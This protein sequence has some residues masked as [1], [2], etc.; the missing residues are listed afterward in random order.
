MIGPRACGE[1]IKFF[2]ASRYIALGMA[3]QLSLSKSNNVRRWARV[4]GA[5]GLLACTIAAG[6]S[7]GGYQDG[8]DTDKKKDG[9]VYD[10]AGFDLRHGDS[11]DGGNSDGGT[12]L[13]MN[14]RDLATAP[15]L[16]VSTDPFEPTSCSAPA[17]SSTQALAIL[18]TST[19]M[20]L[21][22]ATLYRRQRTCTGTTP[23][24]CGAWSAAVPHEQLL[25]TYSGGVTTD[26]K[27]FSFPTHLILFQQGGQPKLSIRHTS[28]YLHDAS[29]DT[30]GV[31]FAFGADPMLNTYPVI[32]VWDFA[33]KPSRYEDLAGRLGDKAMLHAAEHC[34]RVVIPTGVTQEIAA[35]YTY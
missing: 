1:F 21:A 15:D 11:E 16:S 6:C 2:A 19:R 33:P 17:L 20:K 31:V 5:F 8:D 14:P 25:L 32:N 26:Y 7:R 12:D 3:V 13:G 24:T 35:L 4:F 22:D 18:G 28:D 29:K 30:R 9:S 34:A 10:G 27:N 23:D